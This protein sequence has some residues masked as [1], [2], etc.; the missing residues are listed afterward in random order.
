M[1]PSEIAK[2][3]LTQFDVKIVMIVI[4]INIYN[5]KKFLFAHDL[6]FIC[7]NKTME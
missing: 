1:K 3:K 7:T 6:C 2:K 5:N 4:N